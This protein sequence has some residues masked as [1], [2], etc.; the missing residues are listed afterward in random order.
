MDNVVTL[1]TELDDAEQWWLATHERARD[2]E[3]AA[4]KRLI[5]TASNKNGYGLSLLPR[6]T[7]RLVHEARMIR[8]YTGGDIWRDEATEVAQ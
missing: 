4:L 2:K 6:W 3:I 5:E 1:T 8:T 7:R